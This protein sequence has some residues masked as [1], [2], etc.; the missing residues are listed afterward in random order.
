VCQDDL[1]H[2]KSNSLI[3]QAQRYSNKNKPR[4]AP[5]YNFGTGK[6][7][8][9]T[10][11]L[12]LTLNTI[13]NQKRSNGKLPKLKRSNFDLLP[14]QERIS[15][16]E[17]KK[18]ISEIQ[19]FEIT[20][21]DR[22]GIGAAIIKPECRDSNKNKS[23]S[24]HTSFS[25]PS[26]GTQHAIDFLESVFLIK[27][28][29]YNEI[30]LDKNNPKKIA[31]HCIWITDGGGDMN[32]MRLENVIPLFELFCYLKLDLLE[33]YHSPPGHS[34]I[35]PVEQFNKSVKQTL[36]SYWIK[37]K[38]G[39]ELEFKQV[40]ESIQNRLVNATHGGLPILAGIG[41]NYTKCFYSTEIQLPIFTNPNIIQ[42]F[43][44]ERVKNL[45]TKVIKSKWYKTT[46]KPEILAQWQQTNPEFY[47][48]ETKVQLMFKHIKVC[49]LYCLV[50]ERCNDSCGYCLSNPSGTFSF[51]DYKNFQ[52]DDNC[53]DKPICVH[54]LN[55]KFI[56]KLEE[57]EELERVTKCSACK[58][59]G[60]NKSSPSC[61][62]FKSN[63]NTSTS[64]SNG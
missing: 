42:K 12:F 43:V 15:L 5:T 16:L 24:N 22:S 18:N 14:I 17:S 6:K 26:N 50:I 20:T 23:E 1:E 47:N 46:V 57:M 58:Q 9:I 49:C 38:Y 29:P 34:K 64:N 2:I 52:C 30:V 37:L 55:Q 61:P 62:L 44:N 40:C 41:S 21:S 32:I 54:K 51:G 10:S 25:C 53:K 60:H 3:G 56:T 35:N 59:T 28:S 11:H 39:T 27:N 36:F 8:I 45:T 33:R 63:T 7:I 48:L 19:T 4:E 13:C 31:P